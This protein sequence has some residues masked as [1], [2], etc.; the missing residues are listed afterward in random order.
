MSL[1]KLPYLRNIIIVFG[2]FLF[3]CLRF[4]GQEG[5]D[6][7]ISPEKINI[8]SG[9]DRSLQLLDDSAQELRGATWS[10]DDTN[11]AEIQ[12][13]EDGRV[14]VHAKAIG[15]VRV[16]AAFNGQIRFRDIRIWPPLQPIPPGTTTWSV[17]PIG[18]EIGDIPAVPT[19]DGPNMFSLEQ[20]SSGS[21]YLRAGREDGIQVWTWLLPESSREVEL[22][23]G[24]WFGGAVVSTK[25]A[26]SYTLYAVG[27]DG[28]TRWK[29]SAQGIRR[30]LAISTEHLVHILT[31]SEDGFATTL[32]GLDEL[33]GEKIFDDQ[34]PVSHENRVN[35][36]REGKDFVCASSSVLSP[37]Q[38][39][40]SHLYVSMDRLA[41][42]AFSQ[43]EW[44]LETAACTPGS[45][46]DPAKI[47]LKW[48]SNLMLWQVHPD[49]T[50]RSTV[51]ETMSG[52][53]LISAPITTASP[54]G[55]LVTDN[56]NGMMIPLRLSHI[57]LWNQ[58]SRPPEEFI[59]HINPDGDVIYKVLLPTYIGPLQDEMVGGEDVFFATRGDILLALN[60]HTGEIIWRWNSHAGG[61]TVFAA[62]ANGDCLV[63]TPTALV[64]V[65]NN[66]LDV[67]EVVKGKAMMDWLGHMYVKHN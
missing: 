4:S 64:E 58:D 21:T 62:L 22:V 31:Q 5:P 28:K 66:G 15:T 33:S 39:I 35:V 50:Y 45:M 60:V 52:D 17:H 48:V 27:K 30:G 63:Q 14:V 12:E 16:S 25:Q 1:P 24:D 46:I 20:T 65:G 61:I 32:T 2:I 23:C 55:T 38:T 57:R 54:T 37:M 47:Y 49:G 8:Q 29:F 41:Y 26:N 44:T 11:L 13:E 56:L 3:S 67:K 53:Q 36:Q 10:V 19:G 42:V 43:N 34:L 40:N 9:D 7:R 59:Y 18:R 51:V 6:W